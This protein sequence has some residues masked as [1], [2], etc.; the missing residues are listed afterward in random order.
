MQFQHLSF[1]WGGGDE[2]FK[3][4]FTE[5]LEWEYYLPVFKKLWRNPS[6][7]QLHLG[8]TLNQ[9]KM[10][11]L[12]SLWCERQMGRLLVFIPFAEITALQKHFP[13]SQ[14]PKG[15][16]YEKSEMHWNF[17]KQVLNKIPEMWHK[18]I[19]VHFI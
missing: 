4:I 19:K 15:V 3:T 2:N 16:T 18:V 6:R 11:W 5:F 10:P 1:T 9:I 12:S 8:V 13:K 14:L 17:P 7:M